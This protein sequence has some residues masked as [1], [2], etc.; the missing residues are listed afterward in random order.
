MKRNPNGSDIPQ[1]R[2]LLVKHLQFNSRCEH[3]GSPVDKS[4]VTQALALL[5]R[6]TA[7]RRAPE[8]SARV[9]PKMARDIRAYFSAHPTMSLQ[10]IAEHFK[11]NS[12]RVSECIHGQR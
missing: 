4:R 12:G 3:C 6:A 7:V 5:D 9:T 8:T 2:E 10:A 11:T 1:A